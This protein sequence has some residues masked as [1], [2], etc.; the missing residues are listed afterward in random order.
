MDKITVY[1]TRIP[2]LLLK[3]ALHK[4]RVKIDR[5]KFRYYE[6][7]GGEAKYEGSSPSMIYLQAGG[8]EAFSNLGIQLKGRGTK[9]S[10]I[11]VFDKR[12][13]LLFSLNHDNLFSGAHGKVVNTNSLRDVLLAQNSSSERERGVVIGGDNFKERKWNVRHR[14][15]NVF[16]R[17]MKGA[18]R[19]GNEALV[20]NGDKA[21]IWVSGAEE[22]SI[23]FYATPNTFGG[24]SLEK[25]NTREACEKEIEK[26]L[27]MFS[28]SFGSLGEII[29]DQ[30]FEL[31]FVGRRNL[32]HGETVCW[33]PTSL[34]LHPITGQFISYWAIQALF[35]AKEIK[36][37]VELNVI[38]KEIDRRNRKII[39][40]HLQI[41]NYYFKSNIFWRTIYYPNA[42][43]LK[44][45]RF[46]NRRVLKRFAL[47]D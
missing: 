40:E 24:G 29:Q 18:M 33:G 7:E 36:R 39:R 34:R 35:F 42:L 32:M 8:I 3:L 16:L 30:W 19:N 11:K 22:G 27:D 43:L 17:H 14:C 47:F 41:M 5:F 10:G 6:Q 26:F 46:F 45:S 1:T 20:Y 38:C 9:I 21:S 44:S 2:G 25:E 15:P 13:E 31:D 4:E 28:K 12:S 37:G 23:L